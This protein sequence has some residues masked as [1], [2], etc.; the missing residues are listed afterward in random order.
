[1]C[2]GIRFRLTALAVVMV[3]LTGCGAMAAAP[4][5][6]PPRLESTEAPAGYEWAPAATAS[7][8][9]VDGPYPSTGGLVPPNDEP[10]ADVFFE[11]Y[12]VNPFID[13]E[14]DHFSTFAVMASNSTEQIATAAMP[15]SANF[16]LSSLKI[17]PAQ[18]YV[19]K[20]ISISILV[21]NTGDD[22]GTYTV[23]LKI[24][25]RIEE[26]REVTLAGD[27]TDT[28]T[29]NVSKDKAGTYMA[30][31]D[32]LMAP[33]VV[34]ETSIN[35]FILGPIIAGATALITWVAIKLKRRDTIADYWKM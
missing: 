6:E 5:L 14:D 29:F 33:F 4:T 10:Y 8:M 30:D 12:G 23:N 25:D 32:G 28:V 11:E 27:T 2:T 21:S 17:S 18:A 26:T 22:E 16:S 9:P 31:I 34:K 20:T 3:L 13:T 15:T 35:W 19:N 1:M 24:D 7:P